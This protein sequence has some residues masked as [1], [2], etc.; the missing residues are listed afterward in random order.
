MQKIL[1]TFFLTE[2]KRAISTQKLHRKNTFHDLLLGIG[3]APRGAAGEGHQVS[4]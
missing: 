2:D 3:A 1:E 4:E